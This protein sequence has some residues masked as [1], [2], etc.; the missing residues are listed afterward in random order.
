MTNLETPN[1]KNKSYIA[2]GIFALVLGGIGVHK[3]Y[4]GSWGWGIIFILFWWTGLPS[5]SGLIEGILYLTDEGKYNRRYNEEPPS[6]M[7]W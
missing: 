5:I 6:P 3:F 2:A 4:N 1:T 7:K